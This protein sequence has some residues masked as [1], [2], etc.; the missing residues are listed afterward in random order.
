MFLKT[1][2]NIEMK[3]SKAIDHMIDQPKLSYFHQELK[4][5]TDRVHKFACKNLFLFTL[6]RGL[7]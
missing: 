3:P 1:K 7:N 4:I 2:L 5:T 6:F